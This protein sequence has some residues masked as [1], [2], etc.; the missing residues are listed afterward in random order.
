[1]IEK[2][3]KKYIKPMIAFEDMQLN[4]AIATCSLVTIGDCQINT[5]DGSRPTLSPWTGDVFF[6]QSPACETINM[7]YHNPD[8]NVL[9]SLTGLSA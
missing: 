9:A 7:C 8:S 1:M 2:T 6:T 4:S 5:I 3:K